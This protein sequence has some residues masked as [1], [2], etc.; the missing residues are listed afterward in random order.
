MNTSQTIDSVASV[1]SNARPVSQRVQLRSDGATLLLRV[2]TSGW[3][4]EVTGAQRW[5]ATQGGSQEPVTEIIG[6]FHGRR[7]LTNVCIIINCGLTPP[8]LSIKEFGQG[9]DARNLSVAITHEQQD[10]LLCVLEE[11]LLARGLE[12]LCVDSTERVDAESAA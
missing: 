11:H 3:R 9:T 4:V 12:L 1:I 5:F 8:T 10:E 7:T 6:R 2:G